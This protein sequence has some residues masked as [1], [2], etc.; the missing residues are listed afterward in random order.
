MPAKINFNDISI[1]HPE[2]RRFFARLARPR[3]GAVIRLQVYG[4]LLMRN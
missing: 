3:H 2:K 1:T 4:H